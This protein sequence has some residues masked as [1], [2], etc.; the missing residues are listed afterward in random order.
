MASQRTGTKLLA[1]AEQITVQKE[2]GLPPI[3]AATVGE[4]GE[5][6]EAVSKRD[7]WTDAGNGPA[8]DKFAEQMID[9]LN[10]AITAKYDALKWKATA[11]ALPIDSLLGAAAAAKQVVDEAFGAWVGN[12]V[13]P[14]KDRQAQAS[15]AF[16][17]SGLDRTL[18]DAMDPVVRKAIGQPVNPEDM[19]RYLVRTDTAISK[20]MAGHHFD[21]N[22][23]GAEKEFLSTRVVGEIMSKR[24]KDLFE[25]DRLGYAST[26]PGLR[27]AV[28]TLIPGAPEDPG[29]LDWK[30]LTDLA[31]MQRRYEIF[32]TLIHEYIHI[33]E[34]PFLP[35]VSGG[36][37]IVHEGLCEWLTCLVIAGLVGASK[38]RLQSIVTTVEGNDLPVELPRRAGALQSFLSQYTP[39]SEYENFVEA[40]GRVRDITGP[41]NLKAAFFQGHLEFLGMYYNWSGWLPGAKEHNGA[42]AIRTPSAS[43][44][45]EA[46][47]RATGLP[48]GRLTEYNPELEKDRSA[49]PGQIFLP[50]FHSHYAIATY[51]DETE[52]WAQ[53]SRQH[54]V[55]EAELK[56]ANLIEDGTAVPPG[57]WLLVPDEKG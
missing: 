35:V 27:K 4:S 8:E 2:F 39:K 10:K 52:T 29:S 47:G 43:H 48:P 14:A 55:T 56:R 19:A 20:L 18:V 51:D 7:P 25:C 45:I 28:V 9:E 57:T 32:E 50:G 11:R 38:E 49:W 40:V 15:F 5:S 3:E 13:L 36:T 37:I 46:L 34:H 16:T 22:G 53:I 31:P 54:G 21:P 1:R 12:A 17:V 30:L 42:R 6:V 23:T 24:E 26:R 44:S 33:L 41:N